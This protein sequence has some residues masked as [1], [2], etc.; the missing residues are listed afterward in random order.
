MGLLGSATIA[1]NVRGLTG[2]PQAYR[3]GRVPPYRICVGLRREAEPF[4]ENIDGGIDVP[5]ARSTASGTYPTMPYTQ[6]FDTGVA[7]PATGTSL[8][9]WEEA[10][11]EDDLLPVPVGLVLQLT[12]DLTE[13]RIGDLIL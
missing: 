4:V 12:A 7:I 13:Y 6:V 10:V 8:T 11:Y 1:F 9:G 5:A 3:F 2:S